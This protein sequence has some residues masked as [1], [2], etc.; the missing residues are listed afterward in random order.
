MAQAAKQL[1][2]NKDLAEAAAQEQ[3]EKEEEK[4]KKRNRSRDRR[5]KSLISAAISQAVMGPVQL[6]TLSYAKS[7]FSE[8]RGLTGDTGTE[9]G[10]GKSGTD[11]RQAGGRYRVRK[12]L[13]TRDAPQPD[14]L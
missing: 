5:R 7:C 14:P 3:G 13:P 8:A 12:A 11:M 6:S 4:I 9:G 1:R 10:G 2:K